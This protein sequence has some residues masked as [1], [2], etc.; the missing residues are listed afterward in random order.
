MPPPPSDTAARIPLAIP[1]LR[2][3]EAEYLQNCVDDNWVSSAGPHV[4]AFEAAVA[5]ASGVDHGIAIVNGTCALELA[6]RLAAPRRRGAAA[7]RVA[8]PAWTF[9]ATA[10]AAIHAGLAPLFIDIDPDDWTLDPRALAAAVAADPAA[11][12]AI[13]PVHALGQTADMAPILALAAAH[14]IPVVE[15]AAGAIGARHR[16]RP[17]GSLGLAGVVSFNGNKTIT[18]G[19]GGMILTDD[20]DLAGTARFLSAQAR[21]TAHY[22]HTAAAFNYRM[23]NVNAAI[24]LAQMERLDAMLAAKRRIGERYRA[25]LAG[26][27]GITVQPVCDRGD[28]G[29]WMSCVRLETRQAADDLIARLDRAGIDARPF[30][31]SLADQAPYRAF[32]GPP[33]PVAE[34]LSGRVVA[35]PCSSSLTP[36]Q[37][38][39]VIA[40][41][42]G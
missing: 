4:G 20:A 11:I 26:V 23:T 41:I 36:D 35:L 12:A 22:R 40:A 8:M 3:R 30:W 38:T 29:W 15:D 10:N 5:R 1:D 24:G 25:D 7:N 18:A 39:R 34:A 21:P 28:H 14:G 37:Q 2:G 42:A 33:V 27:R 31:E 19:G 13:V 16:G 6:L 9:A 17:A 32:A